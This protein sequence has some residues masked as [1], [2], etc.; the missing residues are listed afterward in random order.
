M[1]LSVKTDV[2]NSCNLK[3]TEKKYEQV[4]KDIKNKRMMTKR[5]IHPRTNYPQRVNY[6]LVHKNDQ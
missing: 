3:N 5:S 4:Q 6:L 2:G 1:V